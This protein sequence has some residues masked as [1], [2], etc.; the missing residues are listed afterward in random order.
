MSQSPALETAPEMTPDLALNQLITAS[1]FAQLLYV[2]AD[3]RIADHLADG[4]PT[5]ADLA[6]KTNTH[7]PSLARILRAL[8]SVGVTAEGDG[9]I[10]QTPLSDFL[11]TD[12]PESLHAMARM[13]GH[14]FSWNSWEHVL[15][16]VR[17]GEPAFD[18]AHGMGTASSTSRRTTKPARR[19]TPR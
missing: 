2:A 9:H 15:H 13:N 14:P 10:H 5:V 16:S 18:H 4:P 8:A 7:A 1:F 3:L 19:S 6:A 17:T 12:A 11:R